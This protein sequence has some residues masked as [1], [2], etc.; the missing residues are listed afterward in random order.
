[1]PGTAVQSHTSLQIGEQLL[2]VV[3]CLMLLVQGA[4]CRGPGLARCLSRS[5]HQWQEPAT[6]VP[7]CPT[8][9]G[10]EAAA[11]LSGTS[12]GAGHGIVLVTGLGCFGQSSGVS[13]TGGQVGAVTQYNK[14]HVSPWDNILNI[15]TVWYE[16][17]QGG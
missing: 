17:K 2:G 5:L 9:S 16:C 8:H 12:L 14:C 7:V 1:M 6:I 13:T 11:W 15:T 3:I 10:S 4:S